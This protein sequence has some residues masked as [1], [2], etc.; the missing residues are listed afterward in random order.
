MDIYSASLIFTMN[1]VTTI[2]YG[3]KYSL[4]NIEKLYTFFLIY[5]GMI[6]FAMIRQRIKMWRTPKSQKVELHLIDEASL[7]FFYGLKAN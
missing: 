2:G 3:D 5:F 1:T 4:T 6:V 7:G